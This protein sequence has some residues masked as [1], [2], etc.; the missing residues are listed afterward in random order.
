[1]RN[2]LFCCILRFLSC[3][4]ND[5]QELIPFIK[6]AIDLYCLARVAAIVGEDCR[7]CL[8]DFAG[9]S[10]G[11][12]QT[13]EAGAGQGSDGLSRWVVRAC[14]PHGGLQQQMKKRL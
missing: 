5:R 4:I 3:A 12:H 10:P 7:N 14:A 6:L 8:Q 1:M 2:K 13:E 11:Y 9:V